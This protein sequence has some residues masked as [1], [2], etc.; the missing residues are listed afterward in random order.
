MPAQL[1]RPAYLD[2]T[3]D[4]QML[5]RQEMGLPILRAMLAEDIRHLDAARPLHRE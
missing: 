2:G 5:K 4:A 1:C 3:H